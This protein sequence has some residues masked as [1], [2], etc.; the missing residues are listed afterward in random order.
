MNEWSISETIFLW[1]IERR[2]RSEIREI[3][4]LKQYKPRFSETSRVLFS[5]MIWK[6]ST[7]KERFDWRKAR[8][9]FETYGEFVLYQSK[10]RAIMRHVPCVGDEVVLVCDKHEVLCGF[11]VEGFQEGQSHW[12]GKCPFSKGDNTGHRDVMIYTSIKITALGDLSTNRGCQRT[13]TT[14]KKRE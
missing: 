3:G 2:E 1:E 7:S 9:Y 8:T 10:G 6:V 12:V 5:S 4:K 11:V 13:W 14:Y